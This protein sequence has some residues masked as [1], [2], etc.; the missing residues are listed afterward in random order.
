MM[1]FLR[2]FW[3]KSTSLEDFFTEDLACRR[4]DGDEMSAELTPFD[5][6]MDVL[7]LEP[8]SIQEFAEPL[9][10]FARGGAMPS[11]TRSRL[12][13][14][15]ARDVLNTRRRF[16]RRWARFV[17]AIRFI[18]FLPFRILFWIVSIPRRTYRGIVNL[19]W[20]EMLM[21][22]KGFVVGMLIGLCVAGTGLWGLSSIPY[23][24]GHPIE[25]LDNALSSPLQAIARLSI[26]GDLAWFYIQFPYVSEKAQIKLKNHHTYVVSDAQRHKDYVIILGQRFRRIEV[27]DDQDKSSV[28]VFILTPGYRKTVVFKDKLVQ[29]QTTKPDGNLWMWRAPLWNSMHLRLY[30]LA[31][32][33]LDA[34][35]KRFSCAGFVHRFLLDGGVHVPILDAWDMA[36]LPWTRVSM[37]E[38]EPG[39]IITIRAATREH[40]R[41]WHHQITH[42][43]VYIGHGKMIHA[44]TAS[45]KSTRSWIRVNDLKD[46]KGRIDKV[47]R[48]PELL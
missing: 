2:R 40:R 18:V 46:F 39:D 10:C 5:A 11:A 32:V 38:L 22:R 36:K 25:P 15:W 30:S 27:Y 14:W 35:Y 17:K 42:V 26:P 41:F 47:L 43:G 33:W 3:K 19:P 9:D 28:Q 34:P 31:D 24:P 6:E 16:F 48:P 20:A 7:E 23:L 8:I 37:D 21:V 45:A 1:T 29:S 12:G 4:L 13:A 44:S